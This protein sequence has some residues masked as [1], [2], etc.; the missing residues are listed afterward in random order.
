MRRRVSVGIL[1]LLWAAWVRTPTAI[2]GAA[3]DRNLPSSTLP[4]KADDLPEWG[5]G[6]LHA[7]GITLEEASNRTA[8][9]LDVN[10]GD[11]RRQ[12]AQASF[13]F[14]EAAIFNHA[15]WIDLRGTRLRLEVLLPVKERRMF[16]HC[17][18]RLL[19]V[20]TQDWRKLY[21]QDYILTEDMLAAAEVV[22][23]AWLRIPLTFDPAQALLDGTASWSQIRVAELAQTRAI[24][25]NIKPAK[26]GMPIMAEIRLG[27]LQLLDVPEADRHRLELAARP[28]AWVPPATLSVPAATLPWETWHL[29]SSGIGGLRPGHLHADPSTGRVIADVSLQDIEHGEFREAAVQ[30]AVSATQVCDR[31]LEANLTG[32][33]LRLALLIPRRSQEAFLGANLRLFVVATA[34]LRKAFRPNCIVTQRVLDDAEPLEDGWLRIWLEFE[35]A[36]A[37]VARETSWS[38]LTVAEVARTRTIGLIINGISFKGPVVLDT[39]EVVGLAPPAPT[40]LIQQSV[41]QALYEQAKQTPDV[42]E[43]IHQLMELVQ[44]HPDNLSARLAQE[45]LVDLLAYVGREP[46]AVDLYQAYLARWGN[47][48]PGWMPV[49]R[50]GTLM[51]QSHRY[52]AA[53]EYYDRVLI[54]EGLDDAR[55]ALAVIGLMDGYLGLGK[56]DKALA[57]ARRWQG[58]IPASQERLKVTEFDADSGIAWALPT[59]AQTIRR[60]ASVIQAW[61]DTRATIR[62]LDGERIGDMARLAA[63]QDVPVSVCVLQYADLAAAKPLDADQAK[64]LVADVSAGLAYLSGGAMSLRYVG[65]APV[66]MGRAGSQAGPQRGVDVLNADPLYYQ[67]LPAVR[68]ALDAHPDG[69]V[70]LIDDYDADAGRGRMVDRD[71]YACNGLIVLTRARP[72]VIIHEILHG[73]GARH[74]PAADPASRMTRHGHVF[75]DMPQDAMCSQCSLGASHALALHLNPRDC[76]ILGW[77]AQPPVAVKPGQSIREALREP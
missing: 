21:A 60:Y 56:P 64:S 14:Q 75:W 10:A 7:E 29:P 66:P 27:A 72:M 48:E 18:L 36:T 23:D 16:L 32:R 38:D 44:A 17:N 68:T 26:T 71:T 34:E 25:V 4:W 9:R 55:K 74:S 6:G 19:A 62:P 15:A 12:E 45:D 76:A 63:R 57:T 39:F 20:A 58:Q 46:E 37:M 49:F 11:P 65:L 28:P 53:V 8:L 31:H 52:E 69:L 33:R 35:P 50:T 42:G 77:P 47:P 24:G 5:F 13:A 61:I 3:S 73:L 70:F 59:S 51:K 22:D 40:S 1:C 30:F 67:A 43:K 2:A 41:S 54:Q